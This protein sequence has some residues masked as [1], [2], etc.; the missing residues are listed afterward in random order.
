MDVKAFE[1]GSRDATAVVRC[2]P[3]T[4]LT[5][6]ARGL[7][8][9]SAHKRHTGVNFPYMDAAR[10][11]VLLARGPCKSRKRNADA[12]DHHVSRKKGSSNLVQCKYAGCRKRLPLADMRVHVARHL[13]SLHKVG[14][15]TETLVQH[16]VCGWCGGIGTCTVHIT[17]GY[18][19]RKD[20]KKRWVIDADASACSLKYKFQLEAGKKRCSNYPVR[21]PLC[22]HA[23]HRQKGTTVWRWSLA[24]HVALRHA[25]LPQDEL[26]EYTPPRITQ[27][28]VRQLHN[29]RKSQR[30]RQQVQHHTTE[31]EAAQRVLLV[32]GEVGGGDGAGPAREV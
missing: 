24:H 11:Q 19:K 13:V 30:Q 26:M 3:L 14:G 22:P 16:D 5:R 23:D 28:D 32:R 21:C 12:A 2:I 1:G 27:Q 25:D 6:L 15:S 8:T 9:L 10:K 4:T 31:V 20:G 7:D 18:N 29:P 17:Y